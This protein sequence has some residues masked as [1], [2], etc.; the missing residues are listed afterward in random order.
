V[1]GRGARLV[2]GLA[3]TLTAAAC[4]QAPAAVG[5]PETISCAAGT[6][7]GQGSSAQTNAVNAWIRNYQVAC[8]EATV[9]YESSGS[10]AGVTAFL[11]GSGDFAGTDSPLTAAQQATADARCGGPA[12][13]LPMA[14]GPIVLAY[15]VAGVGDLRLTPATVAAIFAGKVTAWNDPAIA[16]DNPDAVLPSTPIRTV[17]RQDSSGTTANFT[18]FLTAAAG[19][20]WSFGSGSRWAA[21]GGRA[22]RGSNG[23]ASAVGRTDG[24]IGYVEASYARFHDLAIA[25]VRNGAGE[26]VVPSDEAA[27]VTVGAARVSAGDLRLAVDYRT[28]AAGAYPI[29]VVTY[30]V[31]CRAGVSGLVKSFLG[32]TASSRGQA[33]AARLGYAPLPEQLRSR[34]ADAVA[35]L[36]TT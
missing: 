13:H 33:A 28:T 36:S 10:T 2:V 14:V 17:H 12:V 27:G 1:S 29:V 9:A 11:G 4:A 32:Y 8:P 25:Q 15:T 22:E 7:R 21:P 18:A 5:A 24:A 26:F 19:T 30:E 16:A 3:L 31:V 20:A 34:V 6:V 35:G 23:V